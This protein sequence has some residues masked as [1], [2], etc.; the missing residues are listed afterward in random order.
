MSTV[1]R[2][3]PAQPHLDIPKRE[4][5]E[6]LRQWRARNAEAFERIRQR[7]PKFRSTD[8]AAIA[9]TPFRL[10]DAQL[11]IARE[12]TYPTWSD[13]KRRIE[14]NPFSLQ[15]ELAIRRDDRAQ[16][17]DLLRAHPHL[18]HLHVHGENWGPPMSYA[19]NLGRLEI[20]RAVA[21]LGA[22][23]FQHAFDRALLQGQIETARWL[24]ARGA[25]LEPGIVMGA[26]ETLNPDG[27]G[28]LAELGAPFTDQHG[29]RLAPLALAL[30]TYCRNPARKHAVLDIFVAQGY[31]LPDTPLMAFH[32]GRID[33]LAAHLD[34][35]PGLIERRFDLAEIYPAEL[36]CGPEGRS[37]M[38]W[39]PI[40][41][42]TLLHLAVDFRERE[43]FDWLLARGADPNARAAID[44][45]GFGGHTPLFNAVVCGISRDPGMTRALLDRGA[46]AHARASL[47][48]FLDWREQPRW[49]EAHDVTPEAWARGFPDQSWVNTPALE[50]LAT[51]AE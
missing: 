25:K 42:T 2:G 13:L 26:C 36:G 20:I 41:G 16:V 1:S 33:L 4:A 27:L 43:I 31:A 28:F 22:R 47:R 37:G 11:V 14:S 19:A 10:A 7:H 38:H 30:E 48:K 15:L 50:L 29:N 5:R 44:A 32:R 18:L 51:V 34:R 17:V 3:L 39:T 9:A 46:S 40:G 45:A 12:Y 6:L 35:D 8:D 21:E 49:H 24:H 23:D